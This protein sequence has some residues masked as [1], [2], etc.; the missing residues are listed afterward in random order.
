MC[1]WWRTAGNSREDPRGLAACV[2]IRHHGD[3]NGVTA[4]GSAG[5]AGMAGGFAERWDFR[6][7]ILERLRIAFVP[8]PA[9]L[10]VSIMG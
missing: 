3:P 2:S 4:P 9:M 1:C 8:A 10:P 5:N 6:Y 7:F